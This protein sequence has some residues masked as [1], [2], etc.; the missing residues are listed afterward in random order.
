VDGTEIT[1][2]RSEE[3]NLE[4]FLQQFTGAA[5]AYS[6]RDLAGYGNTT[7]VRVRRGSD[8]AEKDFSAA[9]VSD[10]TL[11][12]WVGAGND[13]FVETWYD[14]SGN[15]NDAVQAV[16]GSQPKIVDAGTYLGKLDFDGVSNLLSGPD[17]ALGDGS[18]SAFVVSKPDSIGPSPTVNLRASSTTGG[19]YA[20][21]PEVAVRCAG[22]TWI[23]SSPASTSE[24][25]LI[26]AIYTSGNLHTGQS[27]YLNGA[28][29]TRTSGTDGTLVD[30]SGSLFIGATNATTSEF[31]GSINEII[32]YDSDQSANREAIENNINNQYDIY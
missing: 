26:S 5:A 14:Q 2:D 23:S 21:T 25:S 24:N 30:S 9:E 31:D 19:A 3:A 18:K 17:I 12:A 6:L 28:S 8:N 13:G 1:I 11:V 27:V 20:I 10:G 22:V 16:A 32:I 7:V 4:S 15:G 29:V